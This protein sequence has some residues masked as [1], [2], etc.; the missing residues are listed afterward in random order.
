MTLKKCVVCCTAA[1]LLG[2]LTGGFA[3]RNLSNQYT[4]HEGARGVYRIDGLTGKHGSLTMPI[5][6]GMQLRNRE[7]RTIRKAN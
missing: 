3:V 7:T 4:L 2:L 1:F 6:V 5:S